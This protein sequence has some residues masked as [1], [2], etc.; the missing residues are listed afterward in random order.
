MTDGPEE[1]PDGFRRHAV[2]VVGAMLDAHDRSHGLNRLARLI[3][4]AVGR[5]ADALCASIES[6][7][8]GRSASSPRQDAAGSSRAVLPV[9]DTGRRGMRITCPWKMSSGSGTVSAFASWISPHR[10]TSP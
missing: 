1:D 6:R 5:P 8:A 10:S 7:C 2:A 4:D 3:G 9:P